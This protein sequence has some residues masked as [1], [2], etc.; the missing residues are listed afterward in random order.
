MSRYRWRR[1]SRRREDDCPEE[2]GPA[3][4][5]GCPD[6]DGDGV[7]DKDD[8][9]PDVVGDLN[10]CPDSDGDGVADKDDECPDQAG[11]TENNG[12]PWPD[13]DGDGVA[14]KDDECPNEA[15]EVIM[16]VQKWIMK[17][18]N[19]LN[20]AGINILFPA[21]GLQVN[22]IQSHEGSRR[23]KIN[24]DVKSQKVWFLYKDMHLKMVALCTI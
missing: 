20:T 1:Y 15:G 13:S 10:G 21:D 6:T 5:N 12:C 8:E 17:V 16:V 11:E 19:A 3:E 24:F 2:A 7:L 23:S 22:G 4:N 14:D 18:L 9:C